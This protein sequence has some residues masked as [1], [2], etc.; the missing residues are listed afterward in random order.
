MNRRILRT[1]VSLAAALALTTRGQAT[2]QVMATLNTF[3]ESSPYAKAFLYS[4]SGF[5]A[6]T[7]RINHDV[8]FTTLQ[9]PIYG[10]DLWT[11]VVGAGSD[12]VFYNS[13]TGSVAVGTV[14]AAGV[15]H[16]E[17]SFGYGY[18]MRGWDTIVMHRGYLFFYDKET[19]YAVVGRFVNGA[20]K[21]YGVW[22]TFR[23]GW[24]HIVST[25]QGLLFY[26]AASGAGAVGDWTYGYGGSEPFFDIVR[27]DFV[28]RSEPSF[29]P[30]WTHIVDTGAGVLF[31]DAA[32]GAEVMT[33]VNGD[34]SVTTRS[35]TAQTIRPGYTSVT[36]IDN[37]VLFYDSASGD[38]AIGGVPLFDRAGGSLVIRAVYPGYFSPGWSHIVK[39]VDQ[40]F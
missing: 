38:V 1:I 4:D 11:H 15:Y 33:D 3:P 36:A 35:L 19:G 24:T 12:T 29:S 30:G 22:S 28:N 32:S 37:D 17:L 23:P 6:A 8:T 14:D 18:F 9:Y 26:D 20:F 34:G 39:T 31:Y 16:N 5:W 25:G 40:V 21:A 27:I 13:Y 10:F 2:A 7:G